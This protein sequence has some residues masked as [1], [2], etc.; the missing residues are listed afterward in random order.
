MLTAAR[1]ACAVV[2]FLLVPAAA[3]QAATD[4][5]IV[6]Y[7]AGAS[8]T[9]RSAVA[10]RAAVV[11]RVGTIAANGAQVVQV[12]GD[13][14]AA[15]ATL[16]RSTAVEYAEPNV[17]L[18]AL[19]IPNDA[20]FSQL[21]GL[22][23]TGQTGGLADADIDAPEGWDAGGLGSFPA[24]G[25]AKIGIVDTG[26]DQSHQDLSGRVSDCGG[27]NNF[28]ISLVVIILGSDPT[29][30]DG[31]CADDNEHGTHVAGTI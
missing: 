14:A 20:Q 5:V 26:I 15:A 22:N 13:A 29:I 4:S 30:V 16:N 28:G 23:N 2:L 1:G 31:K 6:K 17:E 7:K 9:S 11:R 3:S 19:A 8:A 27:V 21:Y 24:T 18:H 10:D 25:G 12:T